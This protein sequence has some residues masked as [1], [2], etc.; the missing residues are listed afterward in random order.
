MEAN[1]IVIRSTM[2][3]ALR[4][5]E[6]ALAKRCAKMGVAAPVVTVTRH[7]IQETTVDGVTH[8]VPMTAYTVTGERPALPGGWQVVASVE[9]HDSGNIVSVAPAFHNDAPTGLHS[10]PATCDHC[11][12]NRQR[13]RTIVI[14]DASGVQHRVGLACLRDFTG[15]DLPK[16]WE[17]DDLAAWGEDTGGGA[18]RLFVDT[19]VRQAFA[20]IRV[21]GYAKASGDEGERNP[22]ATWQRVQRALSGHSN[23][24]PRDCDTCDSPVTP[25]D[26]EAA[27][28]ALKW[29]LATT[30]QDGYI[31]NLR[32][33]VLAESTRKHLA[34]IVSLA[35]TYQR[36]IEKAAEAARRAT[37]PA[38]LKAD[39]P[40]GTQTIS[41]VIISTDT[42]E[43]AYGTRDVMTVRD[44]RG[45]TV[46]GSEPGDT[47]TPTGEPYAFIE[48]GDRI[49]FTATVERSDRDPSFGFF[50]RPRK[51]SII[52][53][54]TDNQVQPASA[55]LKQ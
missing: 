53:Y 32:A 4:G 55:G 20:T 50:K 18:E 36:T 48:R 54:A 38:P 2:E 39:C 23:T 11:G 34:L 46:W 7:F 41:G 47:K 8:H 37:E 43:N 31:A 35:R 28:A 9:H 51:A 16:V 42:Q 5:R 25:A 3:D 27:L 40:T 10:A 15:H 21:H 19:V 13:A 52:S 22:Y 29:L 6:A 26:G 12:H 1:E 33:A 14:R 44:D 30:E 24:C 45:F 49:T 17:L